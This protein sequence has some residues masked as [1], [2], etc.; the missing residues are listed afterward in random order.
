[1]TPDLNGVSGVSVNSGG[2]PVILAAGCNQNISRIE[3][4]FDRKGLT[5]TE[6]NKVL[7]T[8][9]LKSPSNGLVELDLASPGAQWDHPK[10]AELNTER[11]HIVS[12]YPSKADSETSSVFVHL[13]DLTHLKPTKVFTG[14][15]VVIRK[16]FIRDTCK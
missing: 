13:K 1:M 8:W 11:G 3:I 2:E 15:G 9:T 6:Q 14:E 10:P 4:D 7:G 12:V 16:A 5:D